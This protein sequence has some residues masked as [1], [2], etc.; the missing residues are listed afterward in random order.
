MQQWKYFRVIEAMRG[1]LWGKWVPEEQYLKVSEVTKGD[2]CRVNEAMGG[3]E[4]YR[5]NEA[6]GVEG[7][8]SYS[9]NGAAGS[10]DAIVLYR[11]TK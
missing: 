3:G 2:H 5:L 9:I 11:H 7:G 8:V 1:V 4:D 6:T 10:I